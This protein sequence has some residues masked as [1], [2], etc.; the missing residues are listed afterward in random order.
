MRAAISVVLGLLVLA[1]AALAVLVGSAPR[2]GV[3]ARADLRIAHATLIEPGVRRRRDQTLSIHDGR[4]A[5][6]EP[7]LPGE[8]GGLWDGLF[9]M[10]GLVDLHVH[11]PPPFLPAELRAT[12]VLFLEH[13]VTTVRD[14]GSP[15]AWSLRT[16]DEV[17]AGDLAGPRVFSCGPL[18]VGQES[19]PGAVVLDDVREVRRVID[20]LRRQRVDCV[21]VLDTVSPAV[22]AALR[23]E[24]HATGL[25]LIGHVPSAS[26]RLLLDE[27]QHLTGLEAVLRTRHPA[28]LAKAVADSL[29][30][31][32][33]H[34]PTLVVLERFA[35]ASEGRIVC[36]GP[37][38][39]LPRYFQTVLWDP[40]RIPALA[41]MLIDLGFTPRERFEAAKQVVGALAKGG[42]TI[43][44]GTD[45]PTFYNV[46]GASLHEEIALLHEAGL[47]AEE[48][49]AAATTRAYE[50]LRGGRSGRIEPGE[51]AD[52][53]LLRSDPILAIEAHM[54]LDVAAVV[55][56]GRLYSSEALGSRLHEFE[57]FFGGSA[58]A[59]FVDACVRFLFPGAE[60][61]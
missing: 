51:A 7:S 33:A 52:L 37:C 39:F 30:E 50:A 8:T 17:E 3:P 32:A 46:P 13:G 41:A 56:D 47:S 2:A 61:P 11:L 19:W 10:P 5:A 54:P 43:L 9:A 57:R 59:G 31:P 35:R 34:T 44:A 48:A 24:A 4:V 42:V 16:R 18:L 1:A 29:A 49:L 45:S 25:R 27:V 15:W 22:A 12:L 55:V 6:I 38:S 53:V 58:Y 28:A 40:H 36:G 60:P 20:G 26:N 14:A 21:K 23:E